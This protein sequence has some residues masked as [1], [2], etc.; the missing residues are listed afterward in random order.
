MDD[1]RQK[2]R[3]CQPFYEE[4]KQEG[5]ASGSAIKSAGELVGELLGAPDLN[6]FAVETRLFDALIWADV[7]AADG[8]IGE[9]LANAIERGIYTIG[10]DGKRIPITEENWARTCNVVRIDGHSFCN[11]RLFWDGKLFGDGGHG[12]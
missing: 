4:K 3:L 9:P 5:G 8:V 1:F 10:K 11:A 12:A 2:R 6:P 7:E